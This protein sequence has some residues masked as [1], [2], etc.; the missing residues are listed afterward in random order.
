MRKENSASASKKLTV[1]ALVLFIIFTAIN[2]F[3]MIT[4]YIPYCGYSYSLAS[5][6]DKYPILATGKTEGDYYFSISKTPYLGYD[7]FLNVGVGVEIYGNES[8]GF[9]IESLFIYPNIWGDYKYILFCTE[10][11]KDYYGI[12]IDDLGNFIPRNEDEM[13]CE[14]A[15][16]HLKE[17]HSD[18]MQ[19]LKLAKDC[20]GLE[21]KHDLK[22]GIKG[23]VNGQPLFALFAVAFII[24]LFCLII[25]VFI[26]LLKYKFP[27]ENKFTSEMNDTF[28][29]KAE[30]RFKRTI[31]EYE[32]FASE[33]QLL[34]NNPFLAVKKLP[35]KEE[36]LTLVIFLNNKKEKMKYYALLTD[37]QTVIRKAEKVEFEYICGKALST[38]QFI[39]DHNE[40]I[41][42]LAAQANLFWPI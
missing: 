25:S 36:R 39:I 10:N 15:Q 24:G 22:M 33:P 17:N 31:G 6:E 2:V 21:A 29:G 5:D 32:F 20:W 19:F 8:T 14:R 1:L 16:K 40:E 26:W 42:D 4:M 13:E 27:F 37:S 9:I 35:Y 38:N 12:E 3:W 18:V 34:R 11:G 41:A 23:L 7:D 30:Y 28:Y